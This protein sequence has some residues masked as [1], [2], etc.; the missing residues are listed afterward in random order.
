MVNNK[1]KIVSILHTLYGPMAEYVYAE[2]CKIIDKYGKTVNR[3]EKKWLDETDCM[4][5]TYGDTIYND[6]GTCV[7]AMHEFLNTYV[8]DSISA[9]HLLPFYPFSSDDGFSVTDYRRV[10]ED[11]GGW[12]DIKDLSSHYD[13]M[14]DAV[15]NHISSQSE[16]FQNYLEGN[17]DY[18]DFFIA[19]EG[20]PDISS[21]TRPRALPLLSEFCT[22]HGDKRVWTTFSPDQIDLNYKEPKVLLAILDILLM[23]IS[24]GARYIRL[25]AIGFL[26]KEIRH[27]MYESAAEHI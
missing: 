20:D 11:L 4:L 10:R 7:H 16:W 27:L 15:I 18:K 12:D 25:D 17:E 23:Y 2:I 26:W 24:R 1:E 21:V 22:R 13:L 6:R 5:I 3:Q 9:V 14:F 8:Q 19:C